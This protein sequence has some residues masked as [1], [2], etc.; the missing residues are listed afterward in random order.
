MMRDL[1]LQLSK[2]LIY[3]TKPALDKKTPII[4]DFIAISNI[5]EL[6]FAKA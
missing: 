1:I 5:A 2:S 3:S 4:Y 6:V